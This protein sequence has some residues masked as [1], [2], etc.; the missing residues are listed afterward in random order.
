MHL[1][2]TVSEIFCHRL[3]ALTETCRVVTVVG[4]LSQV[5]TVLC[6]SVMT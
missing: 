4:T 3:H 6:C 2:L 1:S 5:V